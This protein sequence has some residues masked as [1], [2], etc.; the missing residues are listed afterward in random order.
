MTKAS[1]LAV[2][3]QSGQS[4]SF[5]DIDTGKPSG[6][7]K[8]MIAEPHELCLDESRELLYCSH[9]YRHGH[10]WAHGDDTNDISIIDITKQEVIG[11]INTSPFRGP[12]ALR[13]NSSLD[14]LFASVEQGFKDDGPGGVISIDLKTRKVVGS[15]PGGSKCH[16]AIIT[17][18]GSKAYTCNKTDPFVSVMD[19]RSWKLIKK[20]EVPGSEELDISPDGRYVYVPTPSTTNGKAPVDP[21]FKV[22]DTTTDEI[23]RSVPL[24]NGPS[25]IHVTS[26][27]TIMVGQYRLSDGGF[28]AP[29]PG[30]MTLFAPDTFEELGTAEVN[31]YPLTLRSSADGSIGYIANIF[32]GTVSVIDLNKFKILRTI[33]VDTTRR[34]DK[35][36]HQGAHGLALF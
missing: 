17:P 12:H 24:A 21:C 19:L 27:G 31:D 15:A 1:T 2:V 23:V 36:G 9:A 28:K 5:F 13:L 4:L 3:S 30:R 10:Y 29:Q 33:D 34:A 7:I 16:W 35:Q 25:S 20:I 11:V 32:S 26:R 18:D 22:I 6:I 8:D 14:V